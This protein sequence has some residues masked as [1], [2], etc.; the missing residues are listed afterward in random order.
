MIRRKSSIGKDL[1]ESAYNQSAVLCDIRYIGVAA[2]LNIIIV[3]IV[4]IHTRSRAG[5]DST[6]YGTSECD[7]GRIEGDQGTI[8]RSCCSSGLNEALG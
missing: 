6:S 3:V 7:V 1:L 2:A 4:N 5:A 8:T